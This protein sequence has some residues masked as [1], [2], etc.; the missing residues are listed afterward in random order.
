ME[1]DL[2]GNVS[3]SAKTKRGLHEWHAAMLFVMSNAPEASLD[4]I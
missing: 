2:R 1:Q 3:E 4:P